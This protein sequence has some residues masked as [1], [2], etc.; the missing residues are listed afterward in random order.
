[1]ST[2]RGELSFCGSCNLNLSAPFQALP[3]TSEDKGLPRGPW[4][5]SP[6]SGT[7][8][9]ATGKTPKNQHFSHQVLDADPCSGSLYPTF[10]LAL[11]IEV[12]VGG[13]VG[14]GSLRQE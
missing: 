7:A 10:T 9:G 12:T 11:R 13:L 5:L 14:R 2:S 3:S 8:A 1:M 6:L 4:T